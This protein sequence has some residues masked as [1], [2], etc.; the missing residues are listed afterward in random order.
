M[1]TSPSKPL[2]LGAILLSALLL[3]LLFGSIFVVQE[4]EQALVVQFGQVQRMVNTG[5]PSTPGLHFKLPF[6]QN[7][8]YYD[9]RLLDYDLKSF[10]VTCGDQKR[11]VVDIFTRYKIIDPLKFYKTVNTESG[12]QKRLGALIP[13]LLRSVIGSFPLTS[14]LSA[15]RSTIMRNIRDQV[16]RA[17]SDL[18]VQVVDFRIRRADLPQKNSEAIFARMISDREK[19]AKE[20]R[21]KGAEAAQLIRAR[22]EKEKL[23]AL[24]E[25][26][27]K[28]QILRGSGDAKAAEIYAL[29]HGKDP[30]FYEFYQFIN[31]YKMSFSNKE[32]SLFILSPDNPLFKYLGDSSGRASSRS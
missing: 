20:F 11:L 21:A 19:E 5:D 31:L 16:N 10:E 7:V 17:V 12:A 13:G 22:A 6:I 27:K 26:K 25:A 14:M 28:A 3:S 15:E 29:A 18:G 30:E 1:T 23:I 4:I 9:K 24:S 2:R 8:I 32:G